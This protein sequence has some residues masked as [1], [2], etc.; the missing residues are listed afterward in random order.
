MLLLF[1]A[2][3]AVIAMPQLIGK[4]V[5][6]APVA[7][8]MPAPP[9][10][11]S[12]VADISYPTDRAT[13][14]AGT[15]ASWVGGLPVAT[16]VPC[17][18]DVLGEVMSVTT[19][20]APAHISTLGEYDDAHPGCRSQVEQYLGTTATTDIL[21]VQWNKNIDVDAVTVGP[22]AHDVAGGSRW[23]ACVVSAVDQIY[24]A[25][26]LRA[27]WQKGTLPDAFGLCWAE[28]LVQRGVPTNCTS[29]H[30][31]Q[32][33]GYGFVSTTA[34]NGTSIVARATP[35]D[36]AAGCRKLAATV[37]GVTDPT[38]GGALAVKVVA[39]T[40]GAPYVQCAVA[41]TGTRKLVGSVIGL[42]TAP[43]PLA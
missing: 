35:A 22:P 39:D 37:M 36:I 33:L 16:I 43:L 29:P 7:Q 8:V 18:G 17:T 6:G 41:V 40:E 38:H 9:A 10:V 27:S 24:P 2:L 14:A 5:A 12:C 4:P 34:D 42:G 15:A 25:T 21:G 32:Q 3:V 26:P 30:R 1:V 19:Q 31:T 13:P 28:N 20:Q 11:G 23:T